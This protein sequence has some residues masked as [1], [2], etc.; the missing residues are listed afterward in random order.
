M[1]EAM[2]AVNREGKKSISFPN[3][4]TLNIPTKYV[5]LCTTSVCQNLTTKLVQR[6]L[7]VFKIVEQWPTFGSSPLSTRTVVIALGILLGPSQ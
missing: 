5:L 7:L 4:E 1:K 3:I 6:A 2:R